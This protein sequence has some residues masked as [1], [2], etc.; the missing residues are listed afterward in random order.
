MKGGGRAFFAEGDDIDE[1]S[2]GCSR[3]CREHVAV[4]VVVL[5]TTTLML[6]SVAEVVADVDGE[7]AHRSF[8]CRCGVPLLSR[9]R[10]RVDQSRNRIKI[11]ATG[12]A[13]G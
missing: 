2:G 3:C 6:H 4:G 1:I 5:L 12:V 8:R 7:F 10:G 9:G 13:T 11:R